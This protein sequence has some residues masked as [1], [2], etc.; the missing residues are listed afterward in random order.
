MKTLS[1]LLTL[2]IGLLAVPTFAQDQ[3]TTAPAVAPN[4]AE[5]DYH[6]FIAYQK[7]LKQSHTASLT[8]ENLTPEKVNKYAEMGKGLG[9]AINEGLGAVTKNVE[10]FSQTSAGKWLMVL[11]T[12][13]VMGNDAVGLVRQA[14]QFAIGGGL[15][16]L[17]VPFFIYIYRRNCVAYPLLK[18]KTKVGFLT[19]K[20]EY[21]GVNDPI[22]DDAGPWGYGVCFVIFVGICAAIMFTH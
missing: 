18:S 7:M 12:W 1:L 4:I 3:P 20:K 21:E 8:I 14:V 15:L 2:V 22:H 11:I 19:I 13:K 17:G 5:M 6:Q 10:Q 9:I 16:I